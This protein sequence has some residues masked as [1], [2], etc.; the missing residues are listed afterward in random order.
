MQHPAVVHHSSNTI[1]VWR[2]TCW[3]SDWIL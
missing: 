3:R 1:L 2:D